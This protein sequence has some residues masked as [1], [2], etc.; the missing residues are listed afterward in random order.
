MDDLILEG[1]DIE[2]EEEKKPS[3]F[4]KIFFG[5]I[6]ILLI[7]LI[8]SRTGLG[9]EILHIFAGKLASHELD[10][11]LSITLND[12]TKI[13]FDPDTYQELIDHYNQRGGKETKACLLG[14]IKDN[15]YLLNELFLPDIIRSDVFSVTAKP[16]PANTLV[17]LHSHPDNRCL[18]SSQDAKSHK[19]FKKIN[20]EAISAVMCSKTRFGFY[21]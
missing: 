4:K 17:P 10:E 11:N 3:L 16:C 8:L 7:F 1:I 6:A 12:G 19:S 21:K 2:E 18:Y 9:P 15:E 20:P 5:F 14:E 13:I